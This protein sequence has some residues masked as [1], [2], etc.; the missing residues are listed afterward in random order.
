MKSGTIAPRVSENVSAVRLASP[1]LCAVPGTY[2]NCG[3]PFPNF[4]PDIGKRV[5]PCPP[6]MLLLHLTRQTPISQVLPRCGCC[7]QLKLQLRRL[8][9]WML[10]APK[11]QQ[12]RRQVAIQLLQ[13][14]D[15]RVTGR[16]QRDEPLVALY[17]K[18]R[19]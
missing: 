12:Q 17:L 2:N 19:F 9:V 11:Q 13:A 15:R 18:V 5:A 14:F 7:L 8:G 4:F 10:L 16:T 1:R 6:R 3:Q